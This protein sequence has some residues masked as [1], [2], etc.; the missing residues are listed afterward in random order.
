MDF[1]VD[2]SEPVFVFQLPGYQV[3]AGVDPVPMLLQQQEV[4]TTEA[5]SVREIKRIEE[6]MLLRAA[7]QEA[8][9]DSR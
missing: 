6:I 4:A 7:A 5:P 3:A 8:I 2:I 9:N 1:V